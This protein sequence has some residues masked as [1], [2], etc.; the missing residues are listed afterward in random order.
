MAF[1]IRYLFFVCAFPRSAQICLSEK[2]K[3]GIEITEIQYLNTHRMYE[4]NTTASGDGT[5]NTK[6][7]IRTISVDCREAREV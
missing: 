2:E 4:A 7:G 6:Y 5:R 3:K 1:E